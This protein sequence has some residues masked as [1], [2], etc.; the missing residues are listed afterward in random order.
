MV[1]GIEMALIDDCYQKY[2]NELL[3]INKDSLKY[4]IKDLKYISE[5]MCFFWIIIINSY[6]NLIKEIENNINNLSQIYPDLNRDINNFNNNTSLYQKLNIIKGPINNKYEQ[7]QDLY[8]Q[9]VSERIIR[10]G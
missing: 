9:L 8:V 10:K 5:D 1:K 2:G 6:K 4:L 7:E 3:I